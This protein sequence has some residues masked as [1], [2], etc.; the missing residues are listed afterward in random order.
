MSTTAPPPTHDDIFATTRWTAVLD[1][2]RSDNTRARAALAELCQ[3]YWY[4]LYACI[5][6]KGH[7]PEDAEDLTQGF[8]ARLLK[9]K[10]LAGVRRERGRFRAFLLASLNHFLADEW[11]RASAQKRDVRRTIALDLADAERRYQ[12]AMADRLTP[13]LVFERQWALTLL[14]GVIQRLCAEYETAGN[15]ALFLALRFSITGEKSSVPYAELAAQ[16]SMS[17]EAVR[18]AVHRLRQRYRQ[19]LRAEIAQ[20]VA[21]EADVEAEME[22]LRRILSS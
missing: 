3:A 13:E 7:S 19:A 4:P 8:F 12:H 21:D 10:S 1:A 22:S 15:G 16:L 20:T 14:E 5:R 9:L 18:V 6:R 17:E 11:D 2:G